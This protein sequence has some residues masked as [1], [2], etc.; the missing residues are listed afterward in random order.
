MKIAVIGAN[1]KA[2]SLIVKEA[3]ERGHEVTAVVRDSSKVN[4]TQVK[5]LEKDL[6]DLTYDD[7]K[8]NDAVIDAFAVWAEDQ[9]YQHK[10]S[11]AHL[12]DILA[13]KPVR[14]LVVGGA[15]SLY[16]DPE[17]KL[18]LMD[19]P[20]F[21]DMFKPLASNMGEAFDALRT[22]KDV[23]WTYLS[24]SADFSAEGVRTGKYKAGGEELMTNS[25]G[26]STISYA[27]Y[28]IAMLDEA[29]LPKHLQERFTVVSE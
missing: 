2:G 24:P 17:H 9:L 25:K 29:E 20:D 14:L 1:G 23:N 19:T 18:R 16:V 4:N 3:L 10:T 8:E 11:L 13:E 22:R 26:L 6:F 7:L 5:I 28:A 15:G 21:P 27:D 12:S